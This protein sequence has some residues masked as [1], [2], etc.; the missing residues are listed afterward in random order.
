MIQR[1]ASIL[2]TMRDDV[3]ALRQPADLAVRCLIEHPG[4]GPHVF[5]DDSLSLR[6]PI[7]SYCRFGLR[8]DKEVIEVTGVMAFSTKTMF[9]IS[10]SNSRSLLL[11]GGNPCFVRPIL[12]SSCSCDMLA[13]CLCAQSSARHPH[14]RDR[15]RLGGGTDKSECG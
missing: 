5:S 9:P 8:I 13:G 1:R 10:R 2:V 6:H 3:C 14:R 12:T 4:I 11:R 15:T 7:C